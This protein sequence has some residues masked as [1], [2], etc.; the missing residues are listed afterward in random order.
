MKKQ[1]TILVAVVAL[2]VA[3]APP[4]QAQGLGFQV[5]SFTNVSLTGLVAV[6]LKNS[7]VTNTSP[8]S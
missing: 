7:E 1:I 3:S 2:A 8:R 5:G 4:I 6:G